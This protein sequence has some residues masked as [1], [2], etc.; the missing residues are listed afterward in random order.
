MVAIRL[1]W[2]GASTK[3]IFL[4][5]TVSEPHFSHFCFVEHCNSSHFSHLYMLVFAYPSLIVTPLLISSEWVSVHFPESLSNNVVLP[6]STWPV[7]PIVISG[8]T[9]S[10]LS[11]EFF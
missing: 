2:P 9:T 11:C 6:V 5:K 4:T 7:M 1:S 8:C 10:A 3:L